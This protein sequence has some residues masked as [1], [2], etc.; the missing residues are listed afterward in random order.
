MRLQSDATVAYVVGHDPTAED[1]ATE[2]AYNTY[3]ID[4]L[5][6]TPINSPGLECIQAVC[7]P[8]QTGYYYFYFEDNGNGGLNYYFTETY[9]DHQSTYEG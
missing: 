2:S 5:T 6:P 9:E 3:F 8:D 4:G 7:S 1:V